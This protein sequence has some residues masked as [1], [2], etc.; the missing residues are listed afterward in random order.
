MNPFLHRRWAAL[1]AGVAVITFGSIALAQ[2]VPDRMVF[3]GRLVR[4]D[5]IAEATPQSLTFSLYDSASGGTPLWTETHG[6]VPLNNGYYTVVLGE[7][8]SLGQVFT[9]GVRYLGVAIQNQSELLPRIELGTVPYAFDSAKLN[10]QSA[11]AFAAASH[12]H[13]NASATSAGFMSAG[14]KSKLDAVPTIVGDGLALSY[15]GGVG[16]E[17]DF[18]GSGTANTVARSDHTHPLPTLSCTQRTKTAPFDSGATASCMSG[19]TVTG[20]GCAD[21]PAGIGFTTTAAPVTNG[22]T[23]HGSGNNVPSANVTATAICCQLQ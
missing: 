22:F 2:A 9:G 11:S 3:T 18:G 5:G 15:D 19:E 16:L 6:N 23:C 4:A 7:S 21:L 12:S 17:V 14:D 10:G 20:G 1:V 13:P 8:S